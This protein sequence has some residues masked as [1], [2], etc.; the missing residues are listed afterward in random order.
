MSRVFIIA[1][2]GV[3]HNGDLD[4]AK[5]MIDAAKDFGAD[6]I[7]FQAFKAENIVLKNAPKANYQK[8]FTDKYESQ[9]DMLKKLEIGFEAHSELMDYCKRSGLIF[10]S[11]P[12]DLASIDMLQK[13]NIG[14]F[15][16]PSGEI[17][18]LPYLRKIGKLK[19]KVIM[20]TGMA[21]F[22][23]IEV[24]LRILIENGTVKKDVV[25]LRPV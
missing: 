18:N 5:K 24:A 17:T 22:A 9:F 12:F 6:A 16:I 19:T 1:E 7:K 3:N 4:V 21:S 10:L 23:E 20:S 8:K 13:L 14:I 2:A 15:K 11:S 25:L